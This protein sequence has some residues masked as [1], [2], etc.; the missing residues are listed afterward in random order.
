MPEFINQLIHKPLFWVIF[1]AIA[2]TIINILLYRINRKTF[3][4][5]YQKP[6]IQI[7]NVSIEKPNSPIALISIYIINPS[8]YKN[9]ITNWQ[10]RSFMF[11]T[12]ID[13]ND[14]DILLPEFARQTFNCTSDYNKTIKY[15]NKFVILTLTD[16]KRRKIHKVFRLTNKNFAT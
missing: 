14:A 2:A 16:L 11:G 4:L 1:T 7:R 15:K 8:S 3:K 13:Q 10:L 6:W 12:T 5:L 9:I